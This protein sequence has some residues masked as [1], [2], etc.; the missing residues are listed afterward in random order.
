MKYVLVFLSVF[1]SL[2]PALVAQTDTGALRGQVTDPSG[3]V[4]QD[5]SLV[6]KPAS[7]ISITTQS[8]GQ[9]MYEFKTVPAGKYSLAV[10]APGFARYENANVVVSNQPLR[11]NVS[12][13]IQ[14]EEEKIQ[15][16][17]TAPTIDVNPANNAGAI[18]ISGQELEAL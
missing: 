5:A 4:I 15:V 6:L 13:I 17:D 16:S 8:D 3:T 18:V 11:L 2:L 10:S 1:L 12:M 7:G 14:V 9:G